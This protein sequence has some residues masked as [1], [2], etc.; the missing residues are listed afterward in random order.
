MAGW[1]RGGQG[2]HDAYMTERQRGNF[3]QRLLLRHYYS[4]RRVSL[5]PER[6]RAVQ[7]GENRCVLCTLWKNEMGSIA[8]L[9]LDLP[10]YSSLLWLFN[11]L[12][13]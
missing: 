12:S 5:R 6:E 1:L 7:T 8:L 3:E 10:G 4:L 13:T 11:K 2:L 9:V